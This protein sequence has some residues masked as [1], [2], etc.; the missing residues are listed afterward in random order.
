MSLSPLTVA[1]RQA[2]LALRARLLRDLQAVWP[3]LRYDDLDSTFPA[4]ARAVRLLVNRDHDA[5]VRLA[6]AYVRAFREAEQGTGPRVMLAP[7]PPEAQV[8]TSLLVTSLVPVKRATGRGVPEQTA[9]R[10]AFVTSSGEASRIV[11]DGGRGTVVASS[12]RWR[13]VTDGAPCAF[14]ALL[15]SRGAVYTSDTAD[16]E[17]HAHCACTAEPVFRGDGHDQASRR[18]DSLYR[19]SAQGQHGRDAL[20]AFR[21]AYEAA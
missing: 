12:V 7:A 13:R 6:A 4:W 18:W 10:R 19:Q 8:L 11:L 5:A 15:A 3:A 14:C 9:M 17:A 1:Y 20:N 2:N 21:R 16:F